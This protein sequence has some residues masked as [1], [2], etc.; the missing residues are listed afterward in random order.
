MEINFWP[1]KATEH[2]DPQDYLQHCE[3]EGTNPSLD[4]FEDYV[5]EK[6]TQKGFK[7]Y[8]YEKDW[9]EL[10]YSSYLWKDE[11]D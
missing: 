5:R 7:P 11:D 4:G 1:L 8:T 10:Q 9:S 2:F 6:M 3:D